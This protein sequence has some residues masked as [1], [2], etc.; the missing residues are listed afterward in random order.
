MIKSDFLVIGSGIAGLNFA[1]KSAKYGKVA[2]IT[3][4]DII[5]SNT[6]YAQGGIAAVLGK[7]DSYKKHINDTLR[8][9]CY[10]NNKKAVEVMVKNAPKEVNQLINLGVGFD[11][12]KGSLSLTKEGGHSKRRIVHVRDITGRIIEETLVFH[13]RNNK[14]I[15]IFEKHIAVDLIKQNNRCIGAQVL[16][17]INKVIKR[18]S[19]KVTVIATGGLC[20]VYKN[21]SNPKIATGDGVAMAYRANA[22]IEDIEFVQFHPTGLNKKGYDHFLISE[23]VRGEGALLINSKGQRF[24]TKYH[25]LKELAPR[26]IVTR[27]ILKELK[28]G[29]VYI[30]MRNSKSAFLRKRFPTIYKRCYDYGIDITKHLIPIAP[31]AHYSCGGIKTNTYG[32]TNVKG[33]F[34]FGEVTCS[35]VHG[36]NRLASNSLL[37]SIVFSSRGIKKSKKYLKNKIKVKDFKKTSI[38]KLPRKVNALKHRLQKIMWDYAGIIKSVKNCRYALKKINDIEKKSN[39]MLSK[40]INYQLIELRNMVI[41]SKLIINVSLTRKESRGVFYNKDF[42]KEKKEWKRHIAIVN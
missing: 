37:E 5:E 3:K 27:A 10:L 14:N 38:V 39:K 12:Y 4:K 32:E 40:G 19:S 9:G 29:P 24:M 34:A 31:V 7:Y 15:Q 26:D 11:R 18:F 41:V 22:V 8:V 21:T 28:K 6:N 30:D 33:L 2:I 36:A 16:D 23:T 25:K 20:Q 1:L 17:S 35:G 13:A 42:P